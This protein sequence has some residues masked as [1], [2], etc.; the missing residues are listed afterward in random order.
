MSRPIATVW[1]AT[2]ARPPILCHRV[3]SFGWDMTK[4]P[5]KRLSS[6]SDPSRRPG[7]SSAA[8]SG[9]K[10]VINDI[11]APKNLSTR[12]N[13]ERMDRVSAGP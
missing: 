8:G 5:T 1:T 12:M 13:G 11:L 9:S 7:A 3:R 2:D 4:L 10:P 6:S